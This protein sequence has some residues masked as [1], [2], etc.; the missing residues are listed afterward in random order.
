MAINADGGVGGRLEQILSE[1]IVLLDG[2]M[3]ALIYSYDLDEAAFR[4]ER[5]ARHPVDLK[6]CTEALVLS[7]P[8][9]IED[10]HRAYLEAG[11]DI[12]ETD[13][14]NGT[15]LSLEEFELQ[16]HVDELNRAAV[17]LA[18]RAADEFTRKDPRKPRFVAGSIG[19]TKKQLSMGIHVEDPGRRDVTFDEMVATYKQQVRAL[20]EGGVDI[21][22][23]ET[24]F[25][26]LVMKACLV[27]IDEVFEEIGTRLPVMISGTIFDNGRTLSMQPIEA[28]YYSISHFDAMSVGINCAVGV[29]LM[30]GPI[31]ALSSISRTRISCYPN[32]GMPDG[33]GG[34]LG[35]RD[36]TAAVLGEFARNGWLNIVGGCCG[37]RP[38][39]IE[40]IGRAVEGIPPR[41]VPEL[42][43]WSTYSGMDPLV[44]R[45]ETNFVMIGE[46]TNITGSK[47]FA[48][49]IKAGDFESALTVAREQVEGGANVVDVN[50]DEGLIDG[51]QAMTR[52]LNLV[53]ADPS[54]ARV[55]MMVDSSKWSVIEAGLKC[56]QGKPIVNSISLKAGEEEFLHQ[57]RLVHRYGAAVVVMAFDEE[58]Q[59]VT[60]DRKVAI[61]E[62]AYELLTEQAGFAPEDIIFDVN[63]LTVG[64]GIEEHNSYAVEFI[65]AVRELKK[66][67]PHCKTSGGVSNVSFSY[68]GNDVVREAMNAAFLYH[69]IRA[70]LDMG[71]VNAGQLE[72]Y[73]EIPKDLLER[74]EDV[75]LNRRPD[76]ADRLTEFAESVKSS[77]KK[78]KAKDL[79]W[80][81]APVAERLKHALITGTIDY[82]DEDTEEARHHY[83]RP[84]H[85]I[86]GPLMDGMN[87]VGDLFGAG[88]M[89]LP[90]VV[91][92][93][94]VMKKAVAYLTPFMEAEKAKAAALAGPGDGDA[95]DSARRARG[96]VL[97]ATVKGDVHDIGKN[98]VGVVLAC[99]DYEIL[100]LGVMVPCETI[101]KE[102]RERTVDM[103]GLS[104]LITPSLDEMVHVAREMERNGFDIPLL[105]G[106]ATTSSK[107][108][109]VKIAPQYHG[110]VVHVM[111]AS[112][113]VG[114]VDRLNRPETREE[115]DRQNRSHQQREREAFGDRRQRKLL[116]YA[117]AR[118][119]KL[120]LNWNDPRP[121]VPAFLG[122]RTLRSIP[123]EDVVPFIDWSPFFLSWELKGKY[124]RIFED[125][126]RGP[127]ARELFD[128]ARDLLGRIVAGRRLAA[129]AVYG[130]FPANSEN[131]DLVVYE[132]ESRTSERMRLPTLRQQ[133][134]RD[135]QKSFRALADYVAP[136][137]SG[138]R[139]Y[140]GAFA[141]TAG[142]GT[143]ELVAE[144]EQD[145]DDYNAI[146]CKALADRLAEALAEML[147]KRVRDEWG[148]G[149][150]ED[151]SHEDL[152]EER[153]RGIRP[154]SGY[155]TS[156]D[157]TEKHDLWRLL[158]AEAAAGIVL[159][160][161]FAMYPGAS[162]SGLY[163]SHPQA[164]YFAVDMITRDQVE[165][166]AKRKG[167]SLREAERWLAPNLAYD[168]E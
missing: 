58:G 30:R 155:P 154:A 33:F 89:F 90:Q 62:R 113:S 78:D 80:R 160:E 107:H 91:K 1:R 3:G 117:E 57:A 41:R 85:I 120:V 34:F 24:S 167:M 84:L 112:K 127:R 83:E 133:W 86:E 136:R 45:P 109:A 25:D 51:E 59:A 8:K 43:H 12:I 161:S 149:R 106:G 128:D 79:S 32:A 67:L 165:S 82:I 23:P 48:R 100:D 2:S 20:I 87:V 36:R 146:M 147:H 129:N 99:N 42:A 17:A 74:V 134:E 158:D 142:I 31:E 143:E 138:L 88:K 126:E 10:I 110:P 14:F 95:Q 130:F 105:I 21:L 11:A 56:V 16:E 9:I 15:A 69:A 115:L 139:D 116:P 111:D 101:L 4:G 92:S 118:Q 77:Q 119:R 46:R 29:E 35:D 162:V 148:Y 37:T 145:H 76:A 168:P 73:D 96:R 131:D 49:L 70:G 104:G 150:E 55:P 71:I 137:E 75:L 141:V 63:I 66:R 102:A 72:V 38:D 124:P 19:P 156:P 44:L 103:I 40:A 13:T 125:P 144:F 64:T 98:I 61:C 94:R 153:Y 68:R 121:S 97:M 81:S 65:E 53:S 152:I 157:H 52:F 6:N 54:I 93:A 122:T 114:V 123:L 60:K 163:F 7:Q 132:D 159:T 164:R 135:G 18:R 26:T 5:F 166:Y 47:R 27:A 28:F 22:L 140:L 108:T 39:W 151:L 50:M